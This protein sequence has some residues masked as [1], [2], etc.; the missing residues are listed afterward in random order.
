MHKIHRILVHQSVRYYILFS[1]S[2]IQHAHR[3]F[4]IRALYVF[5]KYIILEVL[6]YGEN[7]EEKSRNVYESTTVYVAV[8]SYVVMGN[9]T[10]RKNQ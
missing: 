3:E 2:T 4:T 1:D 9:S 8:V 5:R 6:V 10:E 7:P